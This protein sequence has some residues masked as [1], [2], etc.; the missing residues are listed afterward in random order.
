MG[1]W[2]GVLFVTGA[3]GLATRGWVDD[4]A[5]DAAAVQ[6][7]GPV[8]GLDALPP[9]N[10][11]FEACRSGGECPLVR[12]SFAHDSRRRRLNW[13]VH[14]F[15]SYFSTECTYNTRACSLRTVTSRQK[16]IV[17]VYTVGRHSVLVAG[18]LEPTGF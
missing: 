15:F 8:R 14:F 5:A 10:G 17:V 11:Q 3:T 1:P 4:A 18:G 13:S 2:R 7:P 12:R 9:K 16:E 6:P